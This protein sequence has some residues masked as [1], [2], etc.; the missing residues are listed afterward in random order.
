MTPAMC[1]STPR[2]TEP[3]EH[4]RLGHCMVTT[5]P[6]SQSSNKHNLSLLKKPK[7]CFSLTKVGKR[8]ELWTCRALLCSYSNESSFFVTG[9]TWITMSFSPAQTSNRATP[10]K[11]TQWDWEELPPDLYIWA[12]K[13]E[14]KGKHRVLHSKWREW[15]MKQQKQQMQIFLHH[16]F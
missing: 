1:S 7:S 8:T 14:M 9:K 5:L 13:L 16:C 6:L 4:L 11:T 15:F 2:S 10:S 12:S 3:I